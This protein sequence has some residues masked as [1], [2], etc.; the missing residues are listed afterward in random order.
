MSTSEAFQGPFVFGP[1]GGTNGEAGFATWDLNRRPKTLKSDSAKSA[2][3]GHFLEIHDAT[4][5]K[6]NTDYELCH[7]FIFHLVDASSGHFV[8][9]KC[10][11]K[12]HF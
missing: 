9:C 6:I 10:L 3:P 4:S 1:F 2:Y 12:S 7:V 11:P 8:T 5:I